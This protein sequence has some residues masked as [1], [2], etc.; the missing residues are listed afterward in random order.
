M[1][2][3][4]IV[5]EHDLEAIMTA[6][7]ILDIGPGAGIDGGKI[8]AEGTPED[9]KANKNSV[10]GNYLSGMKKIQIPL[11]RRQSISKKTITYSSK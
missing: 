2:N 9:I 5:V 11:K 4:V 1:G 3:T 7:Y 6:D 8:I 10:T